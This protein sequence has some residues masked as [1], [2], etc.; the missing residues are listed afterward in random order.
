MITASVLRKQYPVGH[1][2]FHAGRILVRTDA[3]PIPN[4]MLLE[5]KNADGSAAQRTLLERF[6]VYDCGS[7]SPDAFNRSLRNHNRL[8][9]NRTDILFVSHLDS[10]HVNKIENL[11]GANPPKIVVL[12]YLDFEDLAVL[13]LRDVDSGKV[14]SAVREYVQDPLNWWLRRGVTHVIF[15]EPG[16]DG[17]KPP[18][19]PWPDAPRD[20]D[21]PNPST[22]SEGA[23]A[24][25]VCIFRPPRLH[26]PKGFVSP[27]YDSPQDIDTELPSG[28]MLAGT[29]TYFRLEWRSSADDSWRLADWILLPYVHPVESATR[30]A[31]QKAVLHELSLPPS[32]ELE[33]FARGLLDALR[34]KRKKLV[35]LYS[36]HFEVDQN[37]ISMSLY[38]GPE[39]EHRSNLPHQWMRPVGKA[40]FGLE[41][42]ASAVGWLGSGD[43]RLKK[44]D[45]RKAWLDFFRRFSSHIF[46]LSLPHHGSWKDFHEE[47]LEFDALSVAVATTVRKLER[48]AGLTDTLRC[49]KDAK[50]QPAIVGDKAKNELTFECARYL[51]T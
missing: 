27:K 2:G 21:G 6:Y 17:D 7:E 15:V 39:T 19:G 28:G 4:A 16:R 12:P 25:L 10:D 18:P 26:A 36:D 43:S 35:S 44:T 40:Q 32:P 30:A 24:R 11:M 1:G 8:T 13:F 38:S 33:V 41:M 50:I 48:I 31:F 14:T 23:Q 29:G 51:Q 20:P 46:I 47:I 37:S 42:A 22:T 3:I 49:V 34:T 9:D 45:R 5:A